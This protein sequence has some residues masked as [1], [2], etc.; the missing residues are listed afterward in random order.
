MSD[1]RGLVKILSAGLRTKAA[2]MGLVTDARPLWGGGVV[3]DW[4]PGA[5]QANLEIQSNLA[6]TGYSPIYA[7]CSRISS[8]VSKLGIDLLKEVEGEEEILEKAPKNSPYWQVIRR[9]N[10]YQDR[11]QFIEHWLLCKL[12]HGNAYAYKQFDQRGICTDLHLLDP[13]SV[14]HRITDDGQVYYSCPRE[15]LAQLPN[16]LDSIPSRFI[17][18]DRGPTFWDKLIGVSPMVAAALSGT[19]GLKIQQQSAAFFGNMSRPSGLI[20]GPKSIPP[21]EARRLKEG[22]QE[23]YSGLRLGQTAVLGDGLTYQA[24]SMAAEASQ[25]AEQLG[26]SAVD[27]ATAFGLPA[28]ML[29]QGPMPTSNN[30]AALEQQYYSRTLQSYIEKIEL[31]LTEGLNVPDGYSV[32]FDLGGLMRMDPSSQMDYLTKGVQGMV[33]TPNEARADV[34]RRGVKGGNTIYGQH[35]DHSLA[36]L[37][38]RDRSED[39]FG[40]AKPAAAPAP[41]AA[42][43][44][45]PPDGSSAEDA[46]KAVEALL[47]KAAARF[48]TA[49]LLDYA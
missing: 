16:G 24:M 6:L 25:L 5:W 1:R 3:R 32:E 22:W 11:I 39:P 41:P 7:A 48:R 23:N 31:L 30:V 29:N 44:A 4:F 28:Y 20:T 27:V 14:R 9:P 45:A 47:E 38:E 33:L 2:G 46:A 10:R 8:D 19:L 17:I 26:I 36:A 13:R 43:A 40:T 12:L 42:P 15:L 21:D 35:Q 49:P 34:N 37:D 18:H